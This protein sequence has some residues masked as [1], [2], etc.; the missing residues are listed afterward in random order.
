MSYLGKLLVAHP[1]INDFFHRSVVFI[2][3]DDAQGTLGLVLNKPTKVPIKQVILER[4]M[5]YSGPEHLYKGGPVNESA[6]ILLHEDGWY[7]SNTLQIPKTGLAITSD[8]TMMQKLSMDNAPYEW[9]MCMG[10]AGWSPGQ[11]Q[12]EVRSRY[13]WLTCDAT[14]AIVFAK[15]GERQW[16]KALEMCSHQAVNSFL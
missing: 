6:V 5:N 1:M 12:Q 7:A 4:N 16:Q 15:D 11:L 9:R 3:Q 13:G 10:M 2:Y 8:Q 14:P